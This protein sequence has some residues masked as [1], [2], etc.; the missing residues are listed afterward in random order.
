[1][2]ELD[3]LMEMFGLS[4]SEAEKKVAQWNQTEDPN[5]EDLLEEELS[6]G[7]VQKAPEPSPQR[8]P[9]VIQP[10]RVSSTSNEKP[11][12]KAPI[13]ST[14]DLYKQLR[15]RPTDE[16]VWGD[17]LWR[18]AVTLLVATTSAGKTVLAHRLGQCLASGLA[19]LG[20][21]PERPLRVL[22]IDMESP[23]GA[24]E[25]ILEI[26]LP[27]P[28]W[29]TTRIGIS[30]Q[31]ANTLIHS[32]EYDVII[33]DNLQD[34]YPVKNEQDNAQ[35][36]DQ[37]NYFTKAAKETDTSILVLYNTGKD[38]PESQRGA[39]YVHL[40]RGASA[41]VDESDLTINLVEKN[42][43]CTMKVVKSRFGN[44]SETIKYKWAG[45][46][47][48]ELIS[49]QRVVLGAQ[50]AME[51]AAL[52]I[53]PFE[54]EEIKRAI[55]AEKLGVK[56][57]TSEDKCLVRALKALLGTGEARQPRHGH[58]QRIRKSEGS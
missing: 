1:M 9:P 50:K 57:G 10:S 39:D 37:M 22:H 12:G 24:K 8:K 48:Y 36:I 19:F 38:D 3:N 18:G 2:S 54:P 47:D 15:E 4:R 45:E 43:T 41:R 40:A 53:M 5:P 58:Y 30:Q 21:V 16:N 20:M 14:E 27:V 32:R 56:P 28:G 31:E 7:P 42:G 6:E 26:I 49:H 29:D 35:A 17:L 44:K 51:H 25:I 52:E 33:V 11:A 23:P 13:I 46:Y 34:V 55:V